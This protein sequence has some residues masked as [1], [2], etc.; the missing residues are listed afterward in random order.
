MTDE[1]HVSSKLWHFKTL[2]LCAFCGPK[3]IEWT[4]LWSDVEVR[5]HSD[6]SELQNFDT[7][8]LWNIWTNGK[9]ERPNPEVTES[10]L[11]NHVLFWDFECVRVVDLCWLLYLHH[12]IFDLTIWLKSQARNGLLWFVVFFC[13]SL[14]SLQRT[15]WTLMSPTHTKDLVNLMWSQS[16]E[17]MMT[18]ILN[19]ITTCNYP[20]RENRNKMREKSI[21]KEM[22]KTKSISNGK[23]T[24]PTRRGK[25]WWMHRELREE[26]QGCRPRL[27]HWLQPRITLPCEVLR[28]TYQWLWI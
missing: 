1:W 23:P 14:L 22:I 9:F 3:P 5:A 21:K 16:M 26:V 17:N 4:N 7:S 24:S 8:T 2:G 13:I 25:I 19:Q 28:T 11:L 12:W 18:I 10:I 27:Q 15:C 20:S 6:T